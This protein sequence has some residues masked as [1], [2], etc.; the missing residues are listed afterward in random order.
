MKRPN[1]ISKD[2]GNVLIKGSCKEVS[3]GYDITAGGQDIWDQENGGY[4]KAIYPNDATS[5]PPE[6]PVNFPSTWVRLKRNDNIFTGFYSCDGKSWKEYG[7]CSIEMNKKL[8]LGLAVTSHNSNESAI[9]KFRDI[10]II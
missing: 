5:L 4:S 9:C 2:I 8:Y 1:F 7:S 6:F 3:G 10:S